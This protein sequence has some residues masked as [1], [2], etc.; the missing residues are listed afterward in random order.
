VKPQISIVIPTYNRG[1]LLKD[2]IN[3]CYRSGADLELEII[4]VDDAS[5]ENIPAA[6]ERYEVHY[7][8]LDANSGS[9][10]ARNRGKSAA[11]G[12]YV[13]FL[14]SDDVLINGALREEHA[15]A[16]RTGADIL[17]SGWQN[18]YL[19]ENKVETPINTY[20]PPVFLSTVDDLLQGKAVPTSSALYK[21]QLMDN[22]DWD[23]DLSKLNDWDFFINVALEASSIVSWPQPAYRWRQHS[24]IRITS[25]AS[26][27]KNAK[28]FFLILKKLETSLRTKGEMTPQ[29]ERRLAQYLYK[30]LRGAYRFDPPLG[31]KML[32]E[33]L[34]L[35]PDF[36]PWDEEHSPV[37]RWLCRVFPIHPVLSTYGV[38]RRTL[39]RLES[40]L[41]TR[42]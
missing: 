41:N 37:F 35:D 1:D 22:V 30:E 7:I 13:K 10:A 15:E 16:R 24:G 8:R 28:E 12:E 17:I 18:V 36:A 23:P 9:G 42:P 4:V 38:L 2:A 33:I 40:A 26:F 20:A 32:N 14:D 3:S 27:L 25:A 19:D 11:H 34:E 29:R 5:E 31:K 39:D 21:R 6:L